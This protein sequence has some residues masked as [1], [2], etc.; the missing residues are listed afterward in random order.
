MIA[1]NEVREVA[2]NYLRGYDFVVARATGGFSVPCGYKVSIIDDIP[3]SV[4]TIFLHDDNDHASMV[5]KMITF[6]E[7]ALNPLD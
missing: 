2:E 3:G 5:S 6:S 1:E 7:N 4:H